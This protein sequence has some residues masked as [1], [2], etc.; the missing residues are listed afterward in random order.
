MGL[1]NKQVV[2]VVLEVTVVTIDGDKPALVVA[3]VVILLCLAAFG[4]VVNLRHP[5]KLVA[6]GLCQSR[7]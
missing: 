1:K 5:Q 6:A 3:I 7:P 2:L 4:D